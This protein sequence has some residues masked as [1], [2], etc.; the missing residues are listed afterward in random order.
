MRLF[1]G[2]DF[3]KEAYY[4]KGLQNIINMCSATLKLTGSFHLTL[5]FLGEVPEKSIPLI[6]EQLESVN[7][8]S[9]YVNLDGIGFF[10]NQ[11]CARVLWVGI[12]PQEKIVEL[13][14]KI[15][16]SLEKFN[17][18]R[19]YKFHPHITIAR[20]KTIIN[21]DR[22]LESIQRADIKKVTKKI[23]SFRLVQSELTQKGPI[24]KDLAVFGSKE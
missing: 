24:Y 13:Q 14:Q 11:N 6:K 16:S 15:E 3:H 23:S 19:D 20:I 7:F 1:I 5:K 2:I 12:K 22:L 8:S 21:Q 4:L 17:F 10:P 18:K 9:F